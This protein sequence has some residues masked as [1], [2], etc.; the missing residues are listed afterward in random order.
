MRVLHVVKGLGPGGA[1]RLIVS[2]VEALGH[3][4]EAEVAYVLPQKTHLVPELHALGVSTHLLGRGLADPRW[5]PRLR[6]LV[7]Q[8]HFDIVHLHSP[9]VASVAR[10]ALRPMRDRPALVSTEHNV[11]GSFTAATRVANALTAPLDDVRLAVSEE[12]RS[13]MWPNRRNGVEVLVHGV[14]IDRLRAAT[15][16]RSEVRRGLGLSDDDVVVLIV[17]NFRE[18]KDYPTFL[19][20]AAACGEPTVRFLSVGQGPLEQQLRSKHAAL[21][22]GDRFRF[23][24]YRSDAVEVIAAADIFTL[25]SIHEGLPVALLE[26]MALGVAPVVSSVGGVPEVVTDGV[27]GL[28]V[29]PG[30]AQGFAAAYERLARDLPTRQ[31]LAA[32]ARARAADFDIAKA[33]DHLE[34]RYRDLLE[35]PG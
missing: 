18:K 7:R 25:T 33:A 16:R 15:Q 3:D 26:A 32:A 21:G 31:S 8:G 5:A 2:L 11:W 9:A 28:L 17:A 20:A 19:A 10:L 12:V 1:E 14:P 4:V 6:H 34:H 29:A 35:R 24:G 27:D 22:L 30:D 23:L 13:S